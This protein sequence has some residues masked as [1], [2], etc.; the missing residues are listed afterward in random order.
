MNLKHAA[1][2]PHIRVAADY[3]IA[4][5]AFYRESIW[6]PARLVHADLGTYA[7]WIK[8][9]EIIDALDGRFYF[10][11]ERPWRHAEISDIFTEDGSKW[12]ANFLA[13][14]ETGD[15][16]RAYSIKYER[17]RCVEVYCRA[18]RQVTAL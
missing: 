3:D 1:I 5:R 15:A 18:L 10:R 14:N 2:E 9:L 12:I 13:A 4:N 7:A 8:V 11:D 17:L 16:P 6:K